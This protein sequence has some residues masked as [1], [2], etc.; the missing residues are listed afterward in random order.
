MLV[1]A[2]WR[3]IVARVA[4]ERDAAS[5]Q[6]AGASR[7][8]D[9]RCGAQG[10]LVGAAGTLRLRKQADQPDAH[11]AVAAVRARREGGRRVAKHGCIPRRLQCGQVIRAV[12]I[13]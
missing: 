6:T 11:E 9:A 2:S 10:G 4:G 8:V 13:I 3:A 7:A 12:D 5:T 1:T